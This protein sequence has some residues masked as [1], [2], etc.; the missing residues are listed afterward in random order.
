ME[1]GSLVGFTGYAVSHARELPNYSMRYRERDMDSELPIAG[2]EAGMRL[3][4]LTPI[5]RANDPVCLY[6]RWG[7]IIHQWAEGYTPSYIEVR[8]VI[9]AMPRIVG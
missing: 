1:K 8:E 3:V 4:S 2:W 5:G 6:D 7:W 9:G